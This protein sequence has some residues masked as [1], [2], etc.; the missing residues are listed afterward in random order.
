MSGPNFNI[1]FLADFPDE[2]S[3]IAQWYFDEWAY[4][5]PGVTPS[6]VQEKVLL[7]ANSRREFPLAFVLHDEYNK[8]AAVA[9]LKIR[10]NVHFPEYEHWL[11]GVYVEFSSRGKGYAAALVTHAQN[12]V[13]QL[14]IAKLFLQCEAHNQALYVR[15]GFRPLHKANHNGVETTIMVWES[16]GT[17]R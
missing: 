4:T 10:E 12:H 6:Q 5:V 3:I 14:C 13:L 2:T 11:G 8:L 17:L 7:K 15:H 1:H 16:A 9:E